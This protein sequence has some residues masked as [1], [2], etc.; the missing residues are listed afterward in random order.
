DEGSGL[1]YALNLQ[2]ATAVIDNNLSNS[3]STPTGD[4]LVLQSGDR[5]RDAGAGIPADVIAIRKDGGLHVITPGDNYTTPIN[6]NSGYKTFWYV[7]GE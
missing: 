7:Q 4:V 3:V 2:D 6:T 5:Y 1:T